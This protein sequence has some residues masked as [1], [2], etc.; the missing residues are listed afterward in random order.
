MASAVSMASGPEFVA[1]FGDRPAGR[2][3]GNMHGGN[4]SAAVIDDRCCNHDLAW[5]QLFVR[6]RKSLFAGTGDGGMDFVDVDD[7]VGHSLDEI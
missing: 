6:D 7:G 5:Q 4:R 1:R 3:G 2:V